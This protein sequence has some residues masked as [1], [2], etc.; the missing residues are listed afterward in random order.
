[1]KRLLVPLLLLLLT[2]CGGLPL[3]DGVQSAGSVEEGP[4]EEGGIQVLPPGP[5]PGA[6]A[7]E[8][9]TGFL[10]AM[11]VS[12]EDDHAAARQFLAPGV[13]CCS[14]GPAIAY[15]L[16]SRAIEVTANDATAV[17]V[18]FTSVG[19]ILT[20][21][22]YALEDA[23]LR[24]DYRVVR[25]G[26]E[27][28]LSRVPTGLRI[29]EGD[30][31]RSFTPYDVH[32]LGRGGDGTT[33]ARLVPDRVFLPVTAEPA[34]AL[35]DALLVRGP[36]RGLGDAVQTAVPPGTT[37]RATV[38]SGVVDV[39]LSEQVRALDARARQ[40]LAAQLVWTL[41]PQFSGVRLLVG[42][43]PF[44]V[45]G[46]DAV[47]D[48]SDWAEYDPAGV[49]ADAP[50]LYLRDRTLRSLDDALP[51]SPVTD[52]T[53]P[54]D[55]AAQSPA[56]GQLAVRTRLTSG[57]DEVRTGPVRGPFG[58]P[59][60]RAAGL[61]SLTWGPGD[62]GLWVLQRGRR[63]VV[64]LVPPAD[65]PD[66]RPRA[67]PYDVPDKAGP[68]TALKVSRDGARAALVLGGRLHVARVVQGPDG[69]RIV[70]TARV[71][72]DLQGVVSVAWQSGTQLVALGSFDPSEQ[73]FPAFVAVDGSSVALVQRPLAGAV[74]SEVAAAPRRPLVVA[75]EL[76]GRRRLFRDNG[77]RFT[78]QQP[79]G[80]AP[81][82]PG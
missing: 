23:R 41:V 53:Q 59:V 78:V 20:D 27:L 18:A 46:A 4:A 25:V 49:A 82:Y 19:R 69:A 24:D 60:L 73:P 7:L 37:G 58:A 48:R 32:F 63:A 31:E 5:Q 51:S 2:G 55:E 17:R 38:R 15:P 42:G 71:A 16:A 77:T 54:V 52:G 28:R 29:F 43:E 9:V 10:Y 26:T 64:W 65:A 62:Q 79:L 36:S 12:P 8:L 30:L 3:P 72:K 74:A 47:Q 35:V 6:T 50:L 40:R 14:P 13:T 75:G 67:V 61:G 76:E 68:L 11:S 57:L 22:S 45:D 39:D 70:G 34:Q 80:T 1:M 81:F 56:T 44:E 21:G 66:L 33:V